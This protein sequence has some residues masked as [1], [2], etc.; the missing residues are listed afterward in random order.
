[1][2]DNVQK[3][4]LKAEGIGR[5]GIWGQLLLSYSLLFKVSSV[6]SGGNAPLCYTQGKALVL[7]IE[8]R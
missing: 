8:N 1:M 4:N 3:S 6:Q 2:G 5:G 7:T